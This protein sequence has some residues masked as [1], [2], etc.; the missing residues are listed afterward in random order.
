MEI[1]YKNYILEQS[2]NYF[3]LSKTIEK[4]NKETGLPYHSITN[5]GYGYSL[6]SGI[7]RII[8]EELS[9]Q[10]IVMD[11]KKYLELYRQEKEQIKRLIS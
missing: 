9:T 5:I 4:I 3:D 2:G 6:E 7:T 11:L 1:H 10:D 8:N